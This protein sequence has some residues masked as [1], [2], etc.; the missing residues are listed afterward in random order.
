[1]Y[2]YIYMFIHHVGSIVYIQEMNYEESVTNRKLL[3]NLRDRQTD[4]MY[5]ISLHLHKLESL[6]YRPCGKTA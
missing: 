6:D 5:A 3:L 1:M 4:G 2:I